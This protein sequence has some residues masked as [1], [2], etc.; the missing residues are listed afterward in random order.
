M[1][2]QKMIGRFMQRQFRYMMIRFVDLGTEVSHDSEEK[3]F[4]LSG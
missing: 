1:P 4:L 3:V 2:A